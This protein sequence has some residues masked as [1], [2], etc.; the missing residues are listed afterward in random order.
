LEGWAEDGLPVNIDGSDIEIGAV[1]IK[2]ATTDDRAAVDSSGAISNN[3]T[4]LGGN[5]IATGTG[6]DGTGVQRVS[7]ATNVPLPAGTNVIGALSAN[8]TVNL[9]QVGG[10]AT[11]TGGTAGTLGTGGI[12]ADDVAVSGNNPNLIAGVTADPA[13][14]PA[15]TVAGRLKRLLTNL[16]GILVVQQADTD[17]AFDSVTAWGETVTRVNTTALAASLSIRTSAGVLTSCEVC[18]VNAAAARYIQLHDVNGTPAGGAVPFDIV[19]VP[20]G[21]SNITFSV[22][23]QGYTV[24]NGCTVIE[25][26]TAATYTATAATELYACATHRSS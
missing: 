26:T 1:E 9:A 12:Q 6:V 11:V 23:S 5:A 25:S 24:A 7:L 10:T 21:F 19:Y 15:N 13:A 17:R 18:V 3:T 14:L 4:K 22:P 8:Q 2:D 20:A 16:K